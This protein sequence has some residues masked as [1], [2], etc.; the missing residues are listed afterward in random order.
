M[1]LNS[2]EARLLVFHVGNSLGFGDKSCETL[3]AVV[4]NPATLKFLVAVGN[5]GRKLAALQTQGKLLL[6]N[7]TGI[8][9]MG[10]RIRTAEATSAI[11]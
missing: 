4:G 8:V 5:E 6:P 9:A 3:I 11:T 7:P 10:W 1:A 2:D